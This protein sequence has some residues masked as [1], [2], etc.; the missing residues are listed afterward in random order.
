[1]LRAA[2]KNTVR[3]ELELASPYVVEED[4]PPPSIPVRPVILI[5]KKTDPESEPQYE[6]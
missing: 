1:M 2:N 4:K 3:G 6:S 5:N